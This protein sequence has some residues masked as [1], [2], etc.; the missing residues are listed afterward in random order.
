[1]GTSQFM[2]GPFLDVAI[3]LPVPPFLAAYFRLAGLM[4][5]FVVSVAHR[6]GA[7]LGLDSGTGAIGDP[8]HMGWHDIAVMRLFGGQASAEA[9][10]PALE[11]GRLLLVRSY[12]LET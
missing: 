11:P 2:A 4:L 3:S 7:V 1:M 8:A 6:N 10:L 9:A 5:Q 12:C